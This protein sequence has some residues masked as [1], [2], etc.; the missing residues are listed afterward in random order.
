MITATMGSDDDRARDLAGRRHDGMRMVPRGLRRDGCRWYRQRRRGEATNGDDASGRGTRDR[1][2]GSPDRGKAPRTLGC[3]HHAND[4]RRPTP[5]PRGAS[6]AL[7]RRVARAG[8]CGRSRLGR[9]PSSGAVIGRPDLAR[10]HA[11]T[12]GNPC[13]RRRLLRARSRR[14]L[15]W[16]RSWRDRGLPVLA[17][18]RAGGQ[19][20]CT[21]CR[22]TCSSRSGG[23]RPSS[24]SSG[25]RGR[26]R[27]RCSSGVRCWRRSNAGNV[28]IFIAA[29]IATG[30]RHPG[31]VGV[32]AADEDHARLSDSSGSPCGGSG[33]RCGGSRI[34]T[35]AIV[36]VSFV[37]GA[38][39][40]DRLGHAH[41]RAQPATPSGR[42]PTTSRSSSGCRSRCSSSSSGLASAGRRPS[43]SRRRS[44]RRS[45]TSRPSRSCSGRCRRSARP[46]AGGSSAWSSQLAARRGGSARP[47]TGRS[48]D[49]DVDAALVVGRDD[50]P[51]GVGAS[52]SSSP[53]CSSRLT[54]STVTAQR[55][56]PS[57][58]PGSAALMAR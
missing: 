6:P 37:L 45:S 46:P 54:A 57:C 7:A 18:V 58:Q 34:V 55:S 14:S 10:A 41:R 51:A 26:S 27:C 42:S 8:R 16:L 4:T 48:V 22:S 20:S 43:R 31:Y 15:R 21:C 23:R 11:S 30:F 13:R 17:G 1:T 36:A 3:H 12:G 29:A 56:R 33:G 19:P 52:A 50:L 5:E 53:A 32:R 2:C 49:A 38:G 44:P 39:A 35:G 28:N 47:R 9:R 24:W 40:V 25:S